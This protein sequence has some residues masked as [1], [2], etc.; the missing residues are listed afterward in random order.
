MPH[1]SNPTV[2]EEMLAKMFSPEWLRETA[3]RVGLVK[4]NRKV[5]PVSLFWVL[6]LG[7]GVG[8]QRTL[9]SLRRAY[10]TASAKSIVPSAFYDRF[11]PQLVVFLKESSTTIH[12][13]HRQ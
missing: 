4:R 1:L 6:V 13:R 9:A 10:E 12:R 7:F 5:D 3:S 2:I 11:S 8:V